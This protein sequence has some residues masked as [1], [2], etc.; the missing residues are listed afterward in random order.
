MSK[1]SRRKAIAYGLAAGGTVLAAASCQPQRGLTIITNKIKDVTL[2]LIGSGAAQINDI[3]VQAEKDLG[4]KIKVAYAVE[5]KYFEFAIAPASSLPSVPNPGATSAQ[6]ITT[7]KLKVAVPNDF[8]PFGSV[9]TSMQ[10]QGYNVDIAKEIAQGLKVKL[11]LV[12]VVSNYRIPFLQ[13]NRVDMVISSLGKNKERTKIIDLRGM[14]K[15]KAEEAAMQLLERVGIAH[16]ASRYPGQLSG[17]QQQRVAIAMKPKVMLFDEPT[18]VAPEMVREV[19]DVIRGLANSGMTMEYVT[20]EVG[21]AREVASRVIFL[22]DE[23]LVED[24]TPKEFFN[25][26]KEERTKKFLAQILH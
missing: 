17:G 10:L 21:F 7:G 13:T 12:P 6:I 22:A 16:Q 2:R 26:P 1:I 24:T 3:R 15:A 11:E 5:K 9:S 19:L 8:P 18:F 25:H 14:T 4:F 23:I 20:H